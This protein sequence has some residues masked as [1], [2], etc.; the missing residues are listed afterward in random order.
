MR[1]R[2]LL[3]I[4][5]IVFWL[6]PRS[7][8][9][10]WA[11]DVAWASNFD[12]TSGANITFNYGSAVASGS[13]LMCFVAGNH[14][15][16][17][18]VTGV[19][20]SSANGSWTKFGPTVNTGGLGNA[21]TAWYFPNS[22]AATPVVTATYTASV[23]GRAIACGS[24]TGLATSSTFDVGAGQGQVNPG[25][26]A[27]AVSTGATGTTAGSNELAVGFTMTQTGTLTT[28]TT[29]AWAQQLN[30]TL[31]ASYIIHVEDINIASPATVT[32]TWTSNSAGADMMSMVG[33][34]KEP[35]AAG[36][37]TGGLLLLG[38]GKC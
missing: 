25:T 29:L 22:V 30:T 14:A 38:G 15:S 17:G 24:Y 11:I 9:A 19:E 27:N 23:T 7:A 31:G 16:N 12:N 6:A 34:F 32:A 5:L 35:A 21:L 13:T 4:L 18:V 10:A 20:D 1:L 8:E 36:S 28:G 3:C 2:R 37:C 33:T 26:G